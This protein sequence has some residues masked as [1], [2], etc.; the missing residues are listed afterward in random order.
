ML[1]CVCGYIDAT[2]FKIKVTLGV[3]SQFCVQH[4]CGGLCVQLSMDT[5]LTH[6]TNKNPLLVTYKM[7]WFMLHSFVTAG[8]E[9]D[10]E[11]VQGGPTKQG[12]GENQGVRTPGV[13]G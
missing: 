2:H 9:P 3:K 11:S 6:L 12:N 13:G 8:S 1:T 5:F 7:C 10:Q 4:I